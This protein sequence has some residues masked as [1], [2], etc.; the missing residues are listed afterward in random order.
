MT[1]SKGNNASSTMAE[2]RLC[3]NNSDD[4][5]VTKAT[6]AIAITAKTPAH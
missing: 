3:I 1:S 4:A 5:I 2:T 6:I